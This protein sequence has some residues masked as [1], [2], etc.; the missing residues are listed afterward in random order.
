MKLLVRGEKLILRVLRTIS[1]KREKLVSRNTIS[2]LKSMGYT[3]NLGNSSKV[4]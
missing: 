1:I 2:R 4:W 3:A